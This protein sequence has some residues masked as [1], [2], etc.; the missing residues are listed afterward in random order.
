MVR[1]LSGRHLLPAL[2]ALV[3]VSPLVFML[4]G[5][6]RPAG[7]PPPL[8]VDLLPAEPTLDS[9]RRLP[10]LVPIGSYLLASALVVAV[11]V[12]LTI[13]VASWAGYGIRVLP[14]RR[15]RAAVL[16]V[17]ALLLVPVT[18]VWAT[19][20]EVFRLA[21]ISDSYVPL[22]APALAATSPFLVLVYAWAFG[23]VSDGQL[24]AARLEGAS[25]WRVWARV[26]MP[27]VRPASLAVAVLAFGW[28]WGNVI[29]PLLY[30]DDPGRYPMSLGLDFLRVLGPT[31]WSLLMAGAVVLTLPAVLVLLVA[32]RVLLSD[33]PLATLRA[34]R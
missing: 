2:A 25:P 19:R 7:E 20:F 10:L 22:V 3:L 23:R 13:L 32:Q 18:A 9:Y 16:V 27:Q 21:G 31:D 14:T 28:H 8:G 11:A 15:R 1:A 12:P 24:E 29:D 4:L 17:V 33:D 6:L 26:A 5:S 34:L 30:V